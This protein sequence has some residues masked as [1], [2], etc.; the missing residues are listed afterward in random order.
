MFV[1]T[2]S[3]GGGEGGGFQ[4]FKKKSMILKKI[5][6][7]KKIFFDKRKKIN[8]VFV[9]EVLGERVNKSFGRHQIS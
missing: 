9:S 3:R 6:V 1:D 4:I 2:V 7:C 5:S 8:F